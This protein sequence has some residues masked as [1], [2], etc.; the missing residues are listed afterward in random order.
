MDTFAALLQRV[1]TLGHIFFH[2]FGI[3]CATHQ[4]RVL[5][6]SAVVIT[7]LFYPALAIYS[8]SQPRLLAHFSSQILDPFVAAG[9]IS[10]YYAQHDLWNLWTGQ[11]NLRVR[12]DS[13]ARARCGKEQTLRLERVL[14]HNPAADETAS[15]LSH[16]LL[17]PALHLEQR[18]L[19][20]LAAHKLPCLRKP[21]GRCLVI[22]PL[23]FWKHSE[24]TMLS[25]SD[26]MQTLSTSRDVSISGIPIT[27]E[28]VLAGRETVEYP[29]RTVDQSMFLVLTFFFPET[30]CLGMSGHSAW[31][32]VLEQATAGTADLMTEAQEP[33]LIALE[34]KTNVLS[35]PK[36]SILTVFLYL[37]YFAFVVLFTKVTRV[38]LLVH[39][40]IGLIF[41][42][43]V[44]M[45]VEAVVKTSITLPVK[46]RIA[47]GLSG[48]GTSNSLKVLS[49]NI[50]LG[51]IAKLSDGAIRQFCAFAVVVL[52]AHW[53][54]VHTF[55]VAVLS[56]DLQR[57]E[58]DELLQQDA[59]GTPSLAVSGPGPS[60]AVTQ[61]KSRSAKF[62]NRIHGLLRGRATKNFSLLLLLATTATLYFATYPAVRGTGIGVRLSRNDAHVQQ[63]SVIPGFEQ[64]AAPAWH[65]WH[66]LN[67]NEDPLVHLRVESPTILLFRSKD[68][69]ETSE[70]QHLNPFSPRSRS[71][72]WIVR[73]TVWM[74]RIVVLPITLTCVLLYGLLLYLLKDTERLEAQRNRAEPDAPVKDDTPVE[75]E[76]SFMTLPRALASDV[77]LIAAN[78]DGNVIATVGLENEVAVWFR[79]RKVYAYIDTADLLLQTA[80]TS[81]A[82]STITALAVD[83]AG[84]FCAVGTGAGVIALWSLDDGLAKPLPVLVLQ[85]A[86]SAV[87]SLHF[88]GGMSSGVLTPARAG[89]QA[90]LPVPAL[91]LAAY[92]NGVVAKWSTAAPQCPTMISPS[93][94]APVI[95]SA[96]VRLKNTSRILAAFCMSDGAAELVEVPFSDV[97]LAIDCQILAGNPADTV[98][99]IHASIIRSGGTESVIIA[100]ATQAGVVSLWDGSNGECISILDEAH[101]QISN[102]RICPAGVKSCTQCG[103][104]PVDSFTLSLSI[105]QVVIFYRAIITNYKPTFVTFCRYAYASAITPELLLSNGLQAAQE[106]LIRSPMCPFIHISKHLLFNSALEKICWRYAF[107]Q[108]IM[109]AI[110]TEG[111]VSR[112]NETAMSTV[113]ANVQDLLLGHIWRQVKRRTLIWLR[114]RLFKTIMDQLHDVF[115][116][117]VR[118]GMFMHQNQAEIA[119]LDEKIILLVKSLQTYGA[120]QRDSLLVT[121]DMDPE[122]EPM[123]EDYEL[124]VAGFYRF[125]DLLRF[126]SEDGRRER[127]RN[128]GLRCLV[129][130][131]SA[132]ELERSVLSK[133]SPTLEILLESIGDEARQVGGCPAFKL[134]G[135]ELEC[136]H[137]LRATYEP[138]Y[139]SEP[140][141]PEFIAMEAWLNLGEEYSMPKLKQ[142]AIDCMTS[143]YPPDLDAYDDFE[144]RCCI[145][146]SDNDLNTDALLVAYLAMSH[147]VE[148][149]LPIALYACCRLRIQ[150]VLDALKETEAL[151]L[152]LENEN[153]YVYDTD[154]VLGSKIRARCHTGRSR[155]ST[156]IYDLFASVLRETSSP[157]CKQKVKCNAALNNLHLHALKT[158]ALLN[159]SATIPDSDWLK[160]LDTKKT[161][162]R[163]CHTHLEQIIEQERLDI[164]SKLPEIFSVSQETMGREL[165]E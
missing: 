121:L 84:G 39:N 27:R 105:G 85:S 21:D 18:I 135:H 107:L 55:F 62:I 68:A 118:P 89:G 136:E 128:L 112:L 44:E 7:S 117:L 40:G 12:E 26:I 73:T 43:M 56:I 115:D 155:L 132:K 24:S 139:E 53:F 116:V 126:E 28:M 149:V 20:G 127:M 104:L 71:Q 150:D 72:P 15:T 120:T 45:L 78:K 75:E 13:V 164:W 129:S 146:D 25:D 93:R 160:K 3:H 67:P 23:E 158:D 35:S 49:Y 74:L 94:P 152:T 151:L 33:A 50:I 86:S 134:R 42:G 141:L 29:S 37:A 162:C 83:D 100:A 38:S 161:V 57:L 95:S 122:D 92:E 58:L 79:D 145:A 19:D 9:A 80:S 90:P 48:A 17:L 111:H 148:I 64:R 59:K 130:F 4:I 131:L 103:E 14:I 87:T 154:Y 2:H 30:D 5:L 99:E 22:S 102:V 101:G 60:F 144:A 66:M 70:R 123:I 11:D 153:N 31:R 165:P 142:R 65:I 143:A 159:D 51:I 119:L 77:E 10:N 163:G 76:L 47:E 6:I 97:P 96:L 140:T 36:W 106:R 124:H 108:Y 98:T 157:G 1:R 8:S 147:G 91:V 113:P 41:T 138:R 109:A 61:P 88:L 52:V 54:L 156:A 63:D 137:L 81:S 32:R 133:A 46:E 110:F 69:N 82:A 16:D 34:F 114:I 125:L